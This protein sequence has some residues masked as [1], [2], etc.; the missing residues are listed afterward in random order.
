MDPLTRMRRATA[1]RSAAEKD[2]RAA[3]TEAVAEGKSQRAVAEAAGV[4]HTRVQQ[5][6]RGE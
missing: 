1:R 6:L 5:I 3:I 2:W 4:S